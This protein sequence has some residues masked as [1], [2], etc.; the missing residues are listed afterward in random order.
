MDANSSY[1]VAPKRLRVDACLVANRNLSCAE[2]DQFLPSEQYEVT[3]PSIP[4]GCTR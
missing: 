2:W 1:T 3:C 4:T